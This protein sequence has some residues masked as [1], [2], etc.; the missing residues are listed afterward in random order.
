MSYSIPNRFPVLIVARRKN[1][2]VR[3]S[4][5][6]VIGKPTEISYDV[7]SLDGNL[8]FT[9]ASMIP[10]SRVCSP[11]GQQVD[12]TAALYGDEGRVIIDRTG[13]ARLLVQEGIVFDECA[14]PPNP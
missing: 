14:A 11:F 12:I 9:R 3:P 2:T 10:S 6:T 5:E 4:S 7:Q 8:L 1:G 13:V